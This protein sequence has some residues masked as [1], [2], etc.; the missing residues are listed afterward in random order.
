MKKDSLTFRL[1]ISLFLCLIIAS[2]DNPINAVRKVSGVSLNE[3]S[4]T[5][6]TIGSTVQLTAEVAPSDATEKTVLWT[7]SDPAV[8]SVDSTGLVT[9]EA[10]GSAVITVTTKDGGFSATCSISV[11]VPV[12]GLSLNKSSTN[13]LIG[14]SEQLS[15]TLTPSNAS[16][17]NVSWSSSADSIASVN[18]GGLVSA[19]AEGTA[20][21]TATSEDGSFSDTCTVTVS[22]SS[23]AVTGITLS[24]NSTTINK[25]VSE[26]LV[27][28]IAPAN[29]TNQN[30]SWSSSNEGVVSVSASGE[31]L[32]LDGGSAIITVTSADGSFTDT[33]TVTVNVPVVGIVLNKSATTIAVGATE[34]L[35]ATFNPA[36]ASNQQVSWTSGNASVATVNNSGVITAVGAGS[37]TITVTT[38]D[39]SYSDTCTVIVIVPVTGVSLNKGA[40]TLV[41]GA[42]ETLIATLAPAGASNSAV[43]WTSSNSSIA[44]VNSSGL[45]TA[46]AVGTATITV[47]TADGG[48]TDSCAVTV[49]GVPVTGISFGVTSLNVELGASVALPAVTVLPANATNPSYTV[50]SSN[51][52][53]VMIFGNILSGVGVGTCTITAT[54]NE[55]PLVKGTLTVTVADTTVPTSAGSAFLSATEIMVG[56]S[57]PMDKTSAETLGNYSISGISASVVSATLDATGKAVTLILDSP[58]PAD[59][60][61]TLSISGVQDLYGNAMVPTPVPLTYSSVLSLDTSKLVPGAGNSLSGSA[62]AVDLTGLADTTQISVTVTESAT[63][64]VP[65][66]FA[67]V[68]PDGSIV[69]F[70]SMTLSSFAFTPSTEYTFQIVDSATSKVALTTYTY[71]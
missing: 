42:T 31:I 65:V 9:A 3:T 45:V 26:I 19:H 22:S 43:T 49:S 70:M 63:P 24:K 10:I 60:A 71:P 6:S 50:S 48:F 57:E 35:T 14:S 11:S 64:D 67:T 5:I 69:G 61:F 17:A 32:A 37:A 52:S 55:N 1:L 12:T 46:S 23:I 33:C 15:A 47:T 4:L 56:F 38:S 41:I 54:S 29:A 40:T 62:G 51:M 68:E 36:D 58:A 7:S 34:T 8:A 16:N 21:I 18:A 39:G 59:T 2:C 27:S 13:I 66:A 30:V 28:S 20:T 53:V 44:S 25:G